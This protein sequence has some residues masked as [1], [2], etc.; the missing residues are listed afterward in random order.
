VPACWREARRAQLALTLAVAKRPELL[1][2]DDPV[3]S[4]DPSRF[5]S[6]RRGRV[7]RLSVRSLGLT[8]GPEMLPTGM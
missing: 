5:C 2:L 3:A 6:Y 8:S 1:L 4:L 7:R